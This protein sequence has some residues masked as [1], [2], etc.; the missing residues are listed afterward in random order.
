MAIVSEYT[1]IL[2]IK[3]FGKRVAFASRIVM[4][5]RFSA[6]GMADW[7]PRPRE[8]GKRLLRTLP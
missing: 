6:Q 4:G 5:K 2:D 8:G 1:P 3:A 7:R